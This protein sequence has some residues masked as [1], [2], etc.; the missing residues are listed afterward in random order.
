[1][2][3]AAVVAVMFVSAVATPDLA[4]IVVPL[5]VVAMLALMLALLL[6]LRET[7][8]AKAQLRRRF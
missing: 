1:V 5:F 6:L 4:A 2:L 3:V 8:I 7:L